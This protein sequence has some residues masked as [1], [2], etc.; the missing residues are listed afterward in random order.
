[1]ELKPCDK[2]IFVHAFVEFLLFC[3]SMNWSYEKWRKMQA[4]PTTIIIRA[5]TVT[6]DYI[7]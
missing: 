5:A 6:I 1:M 3:Q 2:M 7:L 4:I